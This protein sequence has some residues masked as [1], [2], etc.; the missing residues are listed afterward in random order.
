MNSYRSPLDT[1][2]ILLVARTHPILERVH[3]GTY[4][5]ERLATLIVGD[6]PRHIIFNQSPSWDPSGGTHWESIFLSADTTGEV[7]SSLGDRPSQPEVVSFMKRHCSSAVYCSTPLQAAG[8]NC[9]GIYCLSHG[10]ARA[11]GISF[12]S[13]LSRFSV[14]D[15]RGN[16]SMM[17]CEFM[18]TMAYPA[19]FTPRVRNHWAKVVG[20]ACSTHP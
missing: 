2:D 18:T 8:S 6:R 13:W 20:E 19:L 10:M 11:R 9:C 5:L 15:R 14:S 4:P 1:E 17:H 3:E 7:F 12:E 16:D